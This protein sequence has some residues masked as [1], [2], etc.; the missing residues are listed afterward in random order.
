MISHIVNH[1]LNI[2]IFY[3]IRALSNLNWTINIRFLKDRKS[4]D[5][6]GVPPAI[7]DVGDRR[8]Y[9]MLPRSQLTATMVYL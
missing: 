6:I 2:F 9:S 1:I 3:S 8:R 5:P 7:V 4:K